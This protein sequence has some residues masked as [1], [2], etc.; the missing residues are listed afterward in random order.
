MPNRTAQI[1]V[2][3]EDLQQRCFIYRYLL[4]KD[5]HWRAIQIR[6]NPGG[7]A[8]R[9]VLDQYPIQVRA[10]RSVPYVSK[11][12]ISMIDADDCT[13]EERKRE[14]DDALADNKQAKRAN[15]EKIA[16][17]VPRRNIETWVHHLL[18]EAVN[19]NDKYPRF[20]GEERKCAPAAEEFAQRCPHHM[21]EAD[22]PSLHDACTE[23]QRIMV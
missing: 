22:P 18:G 20:R 15:T 7:D 2:R 21:R 10:L 19:E 4:K 13:V 23:L 5:V 3:C 12:L 11:A 14:H 8:K 17:L 1:I 6:Q 9:Y 16:V